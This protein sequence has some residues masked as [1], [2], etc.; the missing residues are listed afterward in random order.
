MEN[1]ERPIDISALKQLKDFPH[2]YLDEKRAE[3]W[4]YFPRG[5]HPQKH[6]RK[7]KGVTG[8]CREG[9]QRQM[10]YRLLNPKTGK[11]MECSIGRLM[12]A[13]KYDTSYFKIPFNTKISYRPETGLVIRS[14][15]DCSLQGHQERKER[16]KNE[17]VDFINKHIE[18]LGML[19]EA[20]LGNGARLMRYIAE[21]RDKYIQKL[22]HG[23]DRKGYER[24]AEGVDVAI[25]TLVKQIADGGGKILHI[26]LWIL[27]TAKRLAN[28]KKTCAFNEVVAYRN[29]IK[30]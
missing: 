3:V 26:D 28:N 22:L 16:W 29:A 8:Y 24:I 27:K 7:L 21:N 6:W 11:Y 12:V 14:A 30:I 19:R 2:Y 25:D 5:G 15:A 9:L 1:M 17:R 18:T 4:S 20:Y 23:Y 10:G 13:V